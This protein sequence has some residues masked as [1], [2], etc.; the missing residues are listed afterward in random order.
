MISWIPGVVEEEVVEEE[1]V[2]GDVEGV[3]V[4]L[5][6]ELVTLEK[7]KFLYYVN[8]PRLFSIK[9]ISAGTTSKISNVANLRPKH[10]VIAIGTMYIAKLNVSNNSGVNPAIVVKEVRMTALNRDKEA[11]CIASTTD[12]PASRF[13]RKKLIKTIES[14]TTMPVREKKRVTTSHLCPYP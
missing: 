9:I 12:C 13:L 14:L 8:C 5:I 2:E 6:V 7:Y 11:S 10:I 4:G 3:A 1:V